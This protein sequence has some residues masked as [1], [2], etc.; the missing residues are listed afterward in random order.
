MLRMLSFLVIA[1]A[2][3]NC[4]DDVGSTT[5]T[6]TSAI[7]GTPRT[8]AQVGLD[9]ALPFRLDQPHT[10]TETY[11]PN[12]VTPLGNTCLSHKDHASNGVVL[13]NGLIDDQYAVD[14]AGGSGLEVR[15]A[16][17]GIVELMAWKP[18][19]DSTGTVID[20]NWN[21]GYGLHMHVR[22]PNGCYTHYGHLSSRLLKDKDPVHKG[23]VLGYEGS[24]GVSTGP[25]IHFAVHCPSAG[26]PSVYEPIKPEPLQGYSNFGDV[27]AIDL[28]ANAYRVVIGVASGKEG[29]THF[30]V[31]TLVKR[32]GYPEI[33]LV[34]SESQVCHVKDWPAFVSR[35]F[36]L[37]SNDPMARVTE[38][39]T[40]PR[41]CYGQGPDIVVDQ[42]SK[43]IICAADEYHLTYDSAFAVKRKVPYLA[44]DPARAKLLASWGYRTGE[45]V[46]G[47]TSECNSYTG[48]NLEFRPGVLLERASDDSFL[49]AVP[50]SG[51]YHADDIERAPGTIFKSVARQEL[52]GSNKVMLAYQI[53][54]GFKG[55]LQVPDTSIPYGPYA[56]YTYAVASACSSGSA[57]G[58]GGGATCGDDCIPNAVGCQQSGTGPTSCQIGSDGCYH[59][60]TTSSCAS[61]YACNDGI[62]QAAMTSACAYGSVTCL[63]SHSPATCQYDGTH[64]VNYWYSWMNCDSQ[65]TCNSTFGQCLCIKDQKRCKDASTLETC[66]LMP[67]ADWN[68]WND[69]ACA[70]GWQCLS[71]ACVPTQTTIDPPHTIRCE[72]R[73]GTFT[74]HVTGPI[75]NGLWGPVTGNKIYLEYGADTDGWASY[76]PGS[77]GKPFVQWT[78]DTGG[79]GQSY[80]YDLEMRGNA[81]KM[82]LFLY[83]PDSGQQGWFN[84]DW[85]IWS[86]RGNCWQDSSGLRHIPL[87]PSTGTI[88]CTQNG[89]VMTYAFDGPIEALLGGGA[90]GSPQQIQY[91]SNSDGWTV[92]TSGKIT[93]PWNGTYH[94]EVSLP[95]SVNSLNFYLNGSGGGRWFDLVDSD[96]DG[97]KWT[98]GGACWND[99][100]LIA[101]TMPPKGTINCAVNG[102]TMTVTVTGDIPYGLHAFVPGGSP[103]YLE[104]GSDTDG[105]GAYASGKPKA[106]WSSTTTS[107]ALSLG[108]NVQNMNFFLYGP[109]SGQVSWFDL[110]DWNVTGAC[111]R[112]GGGIKH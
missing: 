69:V 8:L 86:I 24:T 54:R 45:A 39:A 40:D 107:Y 65:S 49:V 62:C 51:A 96:Y 84:L 92:P 109:S 13:W 108:A 76:A 60:A 25:H 106:A 19:F 104:Y 26:N 110:D 68:Y 31:G 57:G 5:S 22:H 78:G 95:V 29:F 53:F 30:P 56:P 75:Q 71:G 38:I 41:S 99:S 74:M 85:G 64:G 43:L 61:G 80:R 23:D 33:Y 18:K 101:H 6:A 63:D 11:C 91:G 102:S 46:A 15:A 55:S 100:G 58:S 98:V 94:H 50:E 67:G 14:F 82:N 59:W 2:L 21:S 1:I 89:A 83:S 103:V 66:Q 3:L 4:G 105:W 87:P 32:I 72:N 35:R 97:D 79:S 17:D 34:C 36:W 28:P 48:P 73:D 42:Q 77:T 27:Q 81:D 111:W 47:T 44:A 70:G 93:A 20:P 112:D 90:V 37:D 9:L 10:I 52:V 7:N 12:N 16:G 88:T